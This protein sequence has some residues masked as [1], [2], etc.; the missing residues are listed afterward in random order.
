MNNAQAVSIVT[1]IIV[2]FCAWV[3][4]KWG[5]KLDGA[6]IAATAAPAMV[7]VAAAWFAHWFHRDQTSVASSGGKLPTNLFKLAVIVPMC[8]LFL[9]GCTLDIP[10]GKAL[11][12]TTRGLY[13]ALSATDSQTGTPSV[14]LGLGSQT[15]MILPTSTNGPLTVADVSDSST[16]DQAINPFSTSGTETFAAGKY[17]VNQT[18][19]A[20]ATQPIVP[21]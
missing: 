8:A 10:Q 3:A 1:K 19:G 6:G 18:N 2:A 9:T 21:K 13:I 5:F 12:V 4:T 20:S 17:Q 14:K 11:S 15:V 16:I 7:S